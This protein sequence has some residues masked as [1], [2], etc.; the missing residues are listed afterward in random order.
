MVC[1]MVLHSQVVKDM[2]STGRHSQVG[3]W[4]LGHLCD[5]LF[6]L[7]HVHQNDQQAHVAQ[8]VQTVVSFVR[9]FHGVREDPY[10][11]V[12]LLGREVPFHHP[13][14]LYQEVQWHQL[15]HTF[16]EAPDFL[17]DQVGLQYACNLGYDQ[18]CQMDLLFLSPQVCHVGQANLK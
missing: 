17:G 15:S 11:H 10:V 2:D 3:L 1:Q 4:A 5:L 14:H 13:S 18:G 12:A 7:V 9:G 6:Q 16:L 8:D